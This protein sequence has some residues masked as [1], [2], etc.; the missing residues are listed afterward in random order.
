[1]RPLVFAFALALTVVSITGPAAAELERDGERVEMS[2]ER[3]ARL[4]AAAEARG[5]A[6]ASWQRGRVRISLPEAKPDGTPGPVTVSID[7]VVRR[8]GGSDGR[9]E[10]PLVPSH[11]VLTNVQLGGSPAGLIA[12]NGLHVASLDPD[13]DEVNVSMTYRVAAVVD[14]AGRAAAI[15]PLPP[16]P[17]AA[18]E[19][20]GAIGSDTVEL[21]PPV[22]L[23]RNGAQLAGELPAVTAISVRWSL[24]GA[25]RAVRRVDYRITPDASGNGMDVEATYQARGAGPRTAVRLAHAGAALI[26]VREGREPLTTY[27]SDDWHHAV[28][29][30]RGDHVV[31]AQFR[32]PIDRAQGRP[33]ISLS[34]DRVPI[35]R[36]EISVPGKR[37]ISFEPAVP[38]TTTVTGEDDKAVTR[39]SGYLPP[40]D[41]VVA[42]WTESRAA[43]EQRDHI[44]SESYQLLTL[45]EGAIKSRV[46]IRYEVIRGKVKELPIAVPEGVMV[47][48]VSGDGVDDWR[49]F[50]ANEDTPR[51]VRVYLGRERTGKFEVELELET[52]VPKAEGSPIVLPLV[53]PIG[54]FREMGVVALFDGDKVGFAPVVFDEA[55]YRKAGQDALPSEIRETL[56]EK[57]NQ[58]FK[59]VGEPGRLTSKVAAAKKREVRFDATVKAVYEVSETSLIGR[60]AVLVEL[61]SGRRD[62]VVISLPEGLAEPRVSAPSLNRVEPVKDPSA[63]PD[64]EGRKGYEVRFTQALEGALQIDVEFEQRLPRELGAI[65]LPDLRVHEAEVETGHVGIATETG[66]EIQPDAVEV[67]RSVDVAEL[68]KAVRLRSERELALGYQYA[69]VP[70]SIVLKVT[71]HETIETLSAVIEQT[72]LETN[73]L[74]NGHIVTRATWKVTN[75]DQQFMQLS[76]PEGSQVLTVATDGEPVKAVADEK[77]G[78]KIPL[79]KDSQFFIDLTFEVTRDKLGV[80]GDLD[81]TAPKPDIRV[82]DV[83]WLVRL[84][85]SFGLYSVDTELE[86]APA[87]QHR[88]VEAPTVRGMD[89]HLPSDDDMSVFLFRYAVASPDEAALSMSLVYGATPGEGLG[90]LA[91]LLALLCFIYVVRRRARRG[92]MGRGG[93][94][95]LA[96]GIFLMGAKAM[97]GPLD[98]LEVG[99][100]VIVLIIVALVSARAVRQAAA[101]DT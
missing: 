78:I 76:L 86:Q 56:R 84:P 99:L 67:A 3:Y 74:S 39:A 88:A 100:I 60:A 41:A 23:S 68:P 65:R 16:L 15:I 12:R 13:D 87:W 45:E 64:L 96:A 36:V 63:L 26:D 61:K 38:V 79:P 97:E 54:A 10:V 91:T 11:V 80:V 62:Y 44:N 25:D 14:G 17:G 59:H 83:Q 4:W 6:V 48:K 18:L 21:T 27:V 24:P 29:T 66:I 81:L 8:H 46:R 69:H 34:L 19:L 32:V 85:S 37:A 90:L 9:L 92:D 93:W 22:P 5:A 75:S 71:A 72:W 20:S 52:L 42:Q 28:V 31:I 95:G 70:W 58:A 77:G 1:M 94:T 2:L 98:P 89:V 33:Q 57:V 82:R 47:N 7:S 73:A 53:R 101:G 49:P 30:G 43:P 35:T 55:R 50:V 51:Q 40:S